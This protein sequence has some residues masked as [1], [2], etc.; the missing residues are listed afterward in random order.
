MKYIPPNFKP[1]EKENEQLS[2]REHRPDR[3]DPS[4][5]IDLS[6]NG[7]AKWILIAVALFAVLASGALYA[8]GRLPQKID[9]EPPE[10][11]QS[12]QVAPT[13]TPQPVKKAT[14]VA[15]A[16]RNN[17][18]KYGFQRYLWETATLRPEWIGRL[19]K[20]I[21]R[22]MLNERR[23][24]AIEA[25]R[26]NGV[27]WF[28]V[29][30]FHER[31]S[32]QSFTRHLHEGSPLQYRTRNVPRGRLPNSKPPYTFEQS[33]EDALYILKDLHKTDWQ[34]LSEALQRIE[35]YNG[36]GYQRHHRD[37]SSPY[38]WS[39]TSHYN[40]GKYVADGRF[41][42]TAIDKQ[43]GVAALLIR[44]NQRGIISYN[45]ARHPQIL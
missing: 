7:A 14:P 4:D 20:T 44:L 31:E 24:R 33:A 1:P 27:P 37:V 11:P 43:V 9:L 30:G 6:Q 26:E 32:T 15:P 35:S 41:S 28:I 42:K 21:A 12:L 17:G 10:L 18:E 34:I 2:V 40:R 25:M 13:P 36:L 8:M 29:A 3:S 16:I 45:N 38:L 19:D 39:G 23:Y 5:Q 22:T